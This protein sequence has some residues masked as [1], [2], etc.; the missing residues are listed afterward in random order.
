M[1][2]LRSRPCR[3]ASPG[4]EAQRSRTS[5]A[6]ALRLRVM[7]SIDNVTIS[8]TIS[9]D[10]VARQVGDETV[11]LQIGSGTYFGLDP[12]GARI[13]QLIE[14]GKILDEICEVLLDEYE[15][16]REKLE[17]DIAVFIK[18]LSAQ[19]LIATS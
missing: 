16:S 2:T 15:V 11:I 13:W 17:A 3:E 7:E 18:G 1:V 5:N 8:L 4:K 19:N 6:L 10:V 9:P 14:E 12:A